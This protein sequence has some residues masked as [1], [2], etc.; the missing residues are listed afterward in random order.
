MNEELKAKL[1]RLPIGGYALICVASFPLLA[2]SLK[3]GASGVYCAL[4]LPGALLGWPAWK[5]LFPWEKRVLLGFLAF[6]VVAAIGLVNTEDVPRGI[7]KLERCLRVPLAIPIYLLLRQYGLRVAK[8]LLVAAPVGAIVHGAQAIAQ[9]CFGP[10]AR[11]EGAYHPI[12]FGDV[13]AWLAAVALCAILTVPQSRPLSLLAWLGV[14]AGLCATI[15]SGTR[16]ALLAI[17]LVFAC[18]ALLRPRPDRMRQLFVA[19]PLLPLGALAIVYISPKPLD[20]RLAHT[21]DE[22]HALRA[23][24][25]HRDGRPDRLAMWRDCLTISMESPLLGTG[26]GDFRLRSEELIAIGQSRQRH[27]YDHAHSI[28]L[29]A[30]AGTGLL[31]LTGQLAFLLVIPFV[32]L[33]RCWR[34]AP[35]AYGQFYALGGMMTL[36]AFAVFGLTE[37]WLSRMPLLTTFLVGVTV[38]L[39]SCAN[40][41][42]ARNAIPAG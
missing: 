39:S 11:A 36:L 24:S 15:L 19:V 5:R 18:P 40:E 29:D 3:H 16:G 30:L 4:L 25:D 9:V 8:V 14:L 23:S 2:A 10:L 41:I 22:L 7:R 27:S 1:E 31:G 17:P 37:A 12:L 6:F 13:S 21:V 32:A 26:L 42:E 28:Y 33:Y 35:T 20:F 38:F 34:Q